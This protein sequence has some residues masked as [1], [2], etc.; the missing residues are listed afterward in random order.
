MASSI[1][2]YTRSLRLSTV[3]LVVDV[4]DGDEGEERG[5]TWM[6]EM[7]LVVSEFW[8][9]VGRGGFGTIG[10]LGGVLGVAVL[11]GRER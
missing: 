8:E 11:E 5:C 6:V 9:T 10:G 4:D 7:E 2:S 1:P 3:D